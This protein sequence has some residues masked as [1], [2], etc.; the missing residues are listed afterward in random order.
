MCFNDLPVASVVE[1][2]KKKKAPAETV[3]RLAIHLRERSV[4]DQPA[5]VCPAVRFNLVPKQSERAAFSRPAFPLQLRGLFRMDF[6]LDF[7]FVP[8]CFQRGP[9][10]AAQLVKRSLMGASLTPVKRESF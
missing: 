10:T 5:C 8:G 3:L 6:F 4:N 2:K 1:L 9:L 7:I